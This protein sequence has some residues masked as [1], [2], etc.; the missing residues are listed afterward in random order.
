M[1]QRQKTILTNV[2]K[3]E[4]GSLIRISKGNISIEKY[5]SCG[6]Q[7]PKYT[8]SYEEAKIEVYNLL[9][10]A[11]QLR[12][13]S[14]VPLGS[15]LSGGI[16][17]EDLEEVLKINH[18]NIAAVDLNSKLEVSTGRKEVEKVKQC[19]QIIRNYQV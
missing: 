3:L 12:M 5:Y 18:L 6:E 16:D 11:T 14:D 1:F 9:E 17:V 10:D 13:I 8:K 19:I 4:A 15:F 7:L 2:D